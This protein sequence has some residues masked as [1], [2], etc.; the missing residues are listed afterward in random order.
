LTV[1][2]SELACKHMRSVTVHLRDAT[3]AEV[4]AFLQEKYPTEVGPPWI[5]P[6]GDDPC[7][8]IGK[9]EFVTDY[10]AN[11]RAAGWEIAE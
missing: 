8:Y 5:E 6:V 7:L 3:E 2:W 9:R 10:P 4:A 11:P 1:T